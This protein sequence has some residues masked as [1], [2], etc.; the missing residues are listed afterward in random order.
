MKLQNSTVGVGDPRVTWCD[1][2][3]G[4]HWGEGGNENR[5]VSRIQ[6]VRKGSL[7]FSLKE[8][9]AYSSDLYFRLTTLLKKLNWRLGRQLKSVAK[10]KQET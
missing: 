1:R 3:Q 10:S 6:T 7:D 2:N 9:E 8:L 4:A 5:D